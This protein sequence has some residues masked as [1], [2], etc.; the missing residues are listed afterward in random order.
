MLSLR[1]LPA[2][3]DRVLLAG[4]PPDRA[5][6][7]LD[8]DQV[9]LRVSDHLAELPPSSAE[10]AAAAFAF[11]EEDATRIAL[12]RL[13][14]VA[15]RQSL[16]APVS[17]SV[18][19]DSS[20]SVSGSRG[21]D[22]ASGGGGSTG[23]GSASHGANG[24]ATGGGSDGAS[25]GG[26]GGAS[27]RGSGSDSRGG[28]G[29]ASGSA[30]GHSG[31]SPAGT[32]LFW[33][34]ACQVTGTLLSQTSLQFS[35]ATY[36]LVR[37]LLSAH[38]LQCLA[39]RFAEATEAAEVLTADQFSRL[40]CLGILLNGMQ[41]LLTNPV[42]GS[43]LPGMALGRQQAEALRDSGVVEHVARFVLV[44]EQAPERNVGPVRHRAAALLIGMFN[45][46]LVQYN[47][48]KDGGDEATC[49]ALRNAL[50]G[51]CA[52]HAVTVHGL[53]VLCAADG[54]PTYGLPDKVWRAAFSACMLEAPQVF[55]G[56][57]LQL[58]EA[59]AGALPTAVT[60]GDPQT[61]VAIRVA[62]SML[63]R[64]LRLLVMSSPGDEAAAQR[65]ALRSLPPPAP[66]DCPRVAVA[67]E[68][69]AGNAFR[70]LDVAWGLLRPLLGAEGPDWAA[71][72]GGDCWRMAAAI[73]EPR[74]L[75]WA[76]PDQL[77]W[78]GE[79]LLGSWVPLL[80]EGE[81]LPSVAPPALATVLAGGLLPRL[82]LLLRRGG[83]KPL[84]SEAALA[85]A[86]LGSG[87]TWHVWS[88]LLAYGDPRQVATLVATVAKLLRLVDCDGGQT[89]LAAVNVLACN[90][91][92][93]AARCQQPAR[94]QVTQLLMY[95]AC[96]WLPELS[97]IVL[98]MPPRTAGSY[99]ASVALPLESLSLSAFRCG[100][101]GGSGSS[102]GN[103]SGS[104]SGSGSGGGGGSGGSAADG[105]KVAAGAADVVG[106]A[107]A[108]DA[109]GWQRLLLGD[110]RA[111][112]LLA[113]A[114]RVAE[115]TPIT[116]AARVAVAGSCCLLAATWPDEVRRAACGSVAI[117][118]GGGGGRSG[119]AAK[120]VAAGRSRRPPPPQQQGSPAWPPELVRALAPELRRLGAPQVA[121]NVEALAV[122]LEAWAVGCDALV[123]PA[124]ERL[125]AAVS[126]A[127][128][129][130]VFGAHDGGFG[131]HGLMGTLVPPAEARALLRT[132]ACT[133]LR[134]DSEEEARPQAC[135][136]CGAEWYCCQECRLPSLK[137][138]KEACAG[139]AKARSG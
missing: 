53:A 64:F 127:A 21:G 28:S 93:G 99:I 58:E 75:R 41:T 137:R 112:Q 12:L 48:A 2:L 90:V 105:D 100:G 68:D 97:R 80:P 18:S 98:E 45:H 9:L 104:G 132:C 73:T 76:D 46:V 42:Y 113:G 121:D 78:L 26:S 83:E 69:V 106:L 110:A 89:I 52:Q 124:L 88:H 23:G 122:L 62:V 30:G 77:E 7:V 72:A 135:A 16:T 10:G 74:V 57:A 39:A 87:D 40:H 138:H 54:G 8:L 115:R 116:Q 114:L 125:L 96:L 108:G 27:G 84:H 38:S 60:F 103:G 109:D 63:L 61:P 65:A 107:A 134:G 20:G 130:G 35:A 56:G 14:P 59:L 91:L 22:S 44:L 24:S 25:G 120:G 55:R 102:G 128:H 5:A 82:E 94:G 131:A 81:P 139:G 33:Q 49:A 70:S 79:R 85:T 136:R 17:A 92:S 37:K 126:A 19:S 4:G 67:A 47:D 50:S 29:R 13:V 43:C 34:I 3:V 36:D 129:G 32:E 11:L 118:A 86:M 15:L 71:E 51:R 123:V 66:S 6:A 133:R 31:S 111:V 95:A 1:R 101:D 117:G 119:T